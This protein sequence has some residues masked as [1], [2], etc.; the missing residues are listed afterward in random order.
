MEPTVAMMVTAGFALI[1][2]VLAVA[3]ILEVT[4]EAV[5]EVLKKKAERKSR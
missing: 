3:L 5:I 1:G 4:T 2:V